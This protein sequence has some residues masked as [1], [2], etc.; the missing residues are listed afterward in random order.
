MLGPYALVDALERDDVVFDMLGSLVRGVVRPVRVVL[1]TGISISLESVEPFSDDRRTG[2]KVPCRGFNAVSEGVLNHLVT[3]RFFIFALFH[4]M[5]IL[6]GAHAV[7]EP[8]WIL[9]GFQEF[10]YV[11]FFIFPVV[12]FSFRKLVKPF[13]D[14]NPAAVLSIVAAD[15]VCGIIGRLASIFR[16]AFRFGAGGLLQNL[17]GCWSF[18]QSPEAF[19]G[20]INLAPDPGCNT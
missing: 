1:E 9:S 14:A 13:F 19:K 15:G 6:I 20:L 3:P 10:Y 18:D 2:V 11:P 12:V 17:P 7:L 16:D 4:D 5:V 8:P